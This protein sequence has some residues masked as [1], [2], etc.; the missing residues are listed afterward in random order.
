[1]AAFM[2]AVWNDI[3]TRSCLP[4]PFCSARCTT[5]PL[6]PFTPCCAHRNRGSQ[7]P[8]EPI[9]KAFTSAPANWISTTFA[10]QMRLNVLLYAR[11][12]VGSLLPCRYALTP[13][14]TQQHRERRGAVQR[15]ESWCRSGKCPAQAAVIA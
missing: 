2:R 8:H 4:S 5:A 11:K 15:S 12:L 14:D 9:R 13:A 1:M 10:R 7:L 3:Q 6:G